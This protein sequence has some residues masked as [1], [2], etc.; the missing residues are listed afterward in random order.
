MQIKLSKAIVARLNIDTIPHVDSGGSVQ[1]VTN[2]R[3]D[4]QGFPQSYVVSDAKWDPRGFAVK[5]NRDSK[6]YIVQRRVGSKVLKFKVADASVVDLES[7]RKRAHELVD[8]AIESGR[9]PNALRREIDAS[10]ITLGDCFRDYLKYLET[11]RDPPAT[12]NTLLA[13]NK[14]RNIF[15][16][17]KGKRVKEITSKMVM[18]KFAEM[19]TKR[20]SAEQAMRWAGASVE[21]ALKTER[22]K[23]E[24]QEREPLLAYNPFKALGDEGLIRSRMKLEEEYKSKQCRNPM[25][26]SKDH[27]GLWI[28][29]LL[30]RRENPQNRTGCDYLMITLLWGA[31]KSESARVAWKD[32]LTREEQTN[33]SWVDL[34]GRWVF[35]CDTK[36]RRTFEFPLTKY[37]Y[38]LL[39]KRHEESKHLAGRHFKWVFPARSLR[40][41]SGHYTDTKELF[42]SIQKDAGI[43]YLRPHDLRRTFGRAL[44]ELNVPYYS[45]KQ[46]L[47]HVDSGDVTGRYSEL[48][49]DKHLEYLQRVEE[50][51]LATQ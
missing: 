34:A 15:S 44:D 8:I 45:S 22:R 43:A 50:Y 37:A 9:N 51:F 7:A 36:N 10:Q 40:S 28:R 21:R 49:K 18:G 17:W 39:S 38:N 13:F 33:T 46:M 42:R 26:I 3:R 1:F 16:D 14:A 2:T 5:V 41:A 31:R 29:A 23:A 12:K 30:K 24:E 19:T 20:T 6:S 25:S 11:D 47:N 32:R 48:E 4:E 27:L 35:F